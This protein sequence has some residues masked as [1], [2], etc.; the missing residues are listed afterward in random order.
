MTL[1]MDPVFL[2]SIDDVEVGED[3]LRRQQLGHC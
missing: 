3:N 1:V 2:A